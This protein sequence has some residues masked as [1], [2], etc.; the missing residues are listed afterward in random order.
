VIKIA[1]LLVNSESGTYFFHQ[2]DGQVN[3]WRNLSSADDFCNQLVPWQS[4]MHWQNNWFCVLSFDDKTMQKCLWCTAIDETGIFCPPDERSVCHPN[5][6]LKNAFKV[7]CLSFHVL[8]AC[9]KGNNLCKCSHSSHANSSSL[10]SLLKWL[11]V[12][13]WLICVLPLLHPAF[14]MATFAASS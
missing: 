12:W 6:L 8:T 4:A 13:R 2:F 9:T 14:L 11:W 1:I 10:A 7:A 3:Q 5:F